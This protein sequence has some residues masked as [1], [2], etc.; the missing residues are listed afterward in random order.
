[1]EHNLILNSHIMRITANLGGNNAKSNIKTL[2]V[3]ARQKTGKLEDH[4]TEC[5][6]VPGMP[7]TEAAAQGM[8]ELRDV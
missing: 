3:Q 1:M 7:G 5:L 6:Y 8:H 2:E 4:G